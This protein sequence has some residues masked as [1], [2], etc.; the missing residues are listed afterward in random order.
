MLKE[1]VK[2]LSVE[3][4]K[5]L[6]TAVEIGRWAD[7]IKLTKKQKQ[8]SLQLVLAWQ[9]L[10]GQNQE[11]MQLGSDGEIVMKSKAVLKRQ[12]RE[13]EIEVKIVK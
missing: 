8:D 3:A 7:G 12:Y 9:A 6:A 11:H 1:L 4:Y 13:P 10:N 5:E 2:S